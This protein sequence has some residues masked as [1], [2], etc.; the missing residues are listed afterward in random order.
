MPRDPGGVF[1][2]AHLEDLLDPALLRKVLNR[3]QV[4]TGRTG[5]AP[6]RTVPPVNANPDALTK[7]LPTALLVAAGL[8]RATTPSPP[9]PLLWD[10]GTNQLLV[11]LA[12][13]SVRTGSGFIDLTL[14]VECDQTGRV[15]VV[16]TFLTATP[17]RP[18]GVVW[19]T[20]DRPRGD[21]TVVN[22]WGDALVALGWRTLL[23]L[24]RTVSA[25]Q[26]TDTFGRP[27][28]ASTAVAG[29]DGLMITAMGAHPFMTTGT[30]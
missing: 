15:E 14:L 29:P 23:E 8:D 9:P 7:L 21:A 19:A 25:A 5:V 10:D 28:V 2:E 26:G 1:G 27:L 18:G 6:G 3:L 24:L 16:S 17:D 22:R 12:A 13:A 11:H 30:P 4:V 20:E